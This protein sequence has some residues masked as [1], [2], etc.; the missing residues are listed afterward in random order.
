MNQQKNLV[1][2]KNGEKITNAQNG[3]NHYKKRV[4]VLIISQLMTATAC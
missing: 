4:T 3:E 1:P 2:L